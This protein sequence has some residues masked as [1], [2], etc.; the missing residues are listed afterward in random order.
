MDYKRYYQQA[1]EESKKIEADMSIEDF[2]K[3]AE[4]GFFE[5]KP[6]ETKG[7]PEGFNAAWYM[8]RLRFFSK[9][10]EE[11]SANIDNLEEEDDDQPLQ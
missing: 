7:E 3:D 2:S 10:Q 8:A 4:G 5:R 11:I 1:L 9:Q 6:E